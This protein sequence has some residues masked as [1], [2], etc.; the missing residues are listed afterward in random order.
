MSNFHQQYAEH[1]AMLLA[2]ES[3]TATPDQQKAAF[4]HLQA[5]KKQ[6]NEDMREAER[7]ARSAYNEGQ[8]DGREEAESRNH[9]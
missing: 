9:Y 6:H 5:V 3:G 2:L 7:E 8:W 1:K 4:A